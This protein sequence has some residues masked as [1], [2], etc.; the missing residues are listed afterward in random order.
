MLLGKCIWERCGRDA[1]EQRANSGGGA[2]LGRVMKAE[3][4]A[5]VSPSPPTTTRA[6]EETMPAQS[7]VDYILLR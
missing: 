7:V 4:R 2:E 5:R 6:R 3:L 1:R